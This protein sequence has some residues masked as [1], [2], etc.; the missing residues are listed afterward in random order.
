MTQF[1][2][3]R[4]SEVCKAI[5]HNLK[6][7]GTEEEVRQTEWLFAGAAGTTHQVSAILHQSNCLFAFATCKINWLEWDTAGF[8]YDVKITYLTI[9]PKKFILRII[10]CSF[11]VSDWSQKAFVGTQYF[12]IYTEF[13]FKLQKNLFFISC[14]AACSNMPNATKKTKKTDGLFFPIT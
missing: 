1:V 7:P 6:R 3:Q 2:S 11:L 10:L 12:K 4:D 9:F 8:F 5:E 13:H 14:K